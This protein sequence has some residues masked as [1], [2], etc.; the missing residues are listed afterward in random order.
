MTAEGNSRTLIEYKDAEIVQE[1]QQDG[2]RV[3]EVK[4]DCKIVKVS[5]ADYGEDLALLMVRCKGAYPLGISAKFVK[6]PNYL[7]PIGVELSHCGSLLGQ[8]GANSY[9]TGVLSQTGRTLAM[10]GANTKVFDQVTAVAFPG[11]SGGGMFLKENGEYIGMLTQGVM[12]L[13]GFNFIV[14]LRRINAWA[15]EAKVEWAIDTTA[16]VPTLKEIEAIPVEDS[17]Q[18]SGGHSPLAPRAILL[19]TPASTWSGS[20]LGDEVHSQLRR[21]TSA[22]VRWHRH[23]IKSSGVRGGTTRL[24][25]PAVGAAMS[26]SKKKVEGIKVD[27]AAGVKQPAI[28]KRIKVSRSVVSDIAT[29]RVHKDVPWP[30]GEPPTPKQAGG[31]HKPIPDYDP[32]N[33]RVM[34]LEA[35][36]VHLT[37]ERNRERQGQGRGEDRW[38]V[39]GYRRGNGTAGRAADR[40]A[41]GLGLPPQGADQRALRDAHQRRPPRPGG[42]A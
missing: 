35:E 30:N 42:P 12:K 37:E 39:Q 15:K 17:G 28:A 22:L 4:Y 9:T 34:E 29:G 18:A 6:D 26:L 21:L 20:G 19:A 14:P 36:V 32:T 10:K 11:S 33:A 8:F 7:P 23:A 5:D 16:K 3:G 41:A 25:L 24:L 31:Q 2:R 1:R 38:L 40:L 27:L 13:Q